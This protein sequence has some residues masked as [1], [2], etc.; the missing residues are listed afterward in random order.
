MKRVAVIIDDG[1]VLKSVK[2]ALSHSGFDVTGMTEPSHRELAETF[3]LILLDVSSQGAGQDFISF[4]RE[5]WP[6]GAVPI[7]LYSNLKEAELQQLAAE[8]GAD[9][10]ICQEWG[11]EDLVRRVKWRLLR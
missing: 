8:A 3:D 5:A 7:F 11:L 4:F 6:I 2:D 9:G 10:Y 1:R